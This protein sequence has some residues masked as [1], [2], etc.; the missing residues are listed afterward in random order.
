MHYFSSFGV[1]F[2][3]SPGVIPK[4]RWNAFPKLLLLWKPTAFMTSVT[5]VVPPDSNSA[6]RL[7]RWAWINWLGVS[8][9]SSPIFR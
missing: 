1:Y 6:A 4:R 9:V 5:L 2:A 3:N 8:S 7:M